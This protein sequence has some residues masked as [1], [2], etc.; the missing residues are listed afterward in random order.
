M[1]RDTGLKFLTDILKPSG[2]VSELAH[3]VFLFTHISEV[4]A[5]VSSNLQQI[6][7]PIEFATA[8]SWLGAFVAHAWLEENLTMDRYLQWLHNYEQQGGRP[9]VIGRGA[10]ANRVLTKTFTSGATHGF[11]YSTTESG[12][13]GPRYARVCADPSSTLPA[14]LGSVDRDYHN[15]PYGSRIKEIQSWPKET[16][17]TTKR[18]YEFPKGP[19][20]VVTEGPNLAQ[21]LQL[22]VWIVSELGTVKPQAVTNAH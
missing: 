14:D 18:T 11:A 22:G 20:T 6:T 8:T 7:I 17:W 9:G 5:T 13:I 10:L 12:L 2:A 3:P 19:L 4:I 15:D 21:T 1:W 16:G